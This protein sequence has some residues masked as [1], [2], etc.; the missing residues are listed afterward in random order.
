[1]SNLLAMCCL[2][3]M[4]TGVT[5]VHNVLVNDDQ[6]TLKCG[7]D[8]GT[9]IWYYRA[10]ENDELILIT[11]LGDTNYITSNANL[12]ITNIAPQHEGFYSCNLVSTVYQLVVLGK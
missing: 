3:S 8:G 9:S 5:E 10:E 4:V 2:V 7:S 6:H 1:M 12:H 11:D